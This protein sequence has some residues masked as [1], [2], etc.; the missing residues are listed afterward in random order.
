MTLLRPDGLGKRTRGPH[1]PA[2][3]VE[4]GLLAFGA[5]PRRVTTFLHR[6]SRASNARRNSGAGNGASGWCGRHVDILASS[7]RSC[8][9]R[10]ALGLRRPLDRAGGR[11]RRRR[12]E[13][14]PHLGRDEGLRATRRG[15]L[16]AIR[17]AD[18]KEFLT[19]E[20]GSPVDEPEERLQSC[21]GLGADASSHLRLPHQKG[22]RTTRVRGRRG[23]A[24]SS[25]CQGC[26]LS[27][28][29]G[30]T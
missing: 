15:R 20:D 27:R 4:P 17:R 18:L 12:P 13:A 29:C 5:S 23:D 1:A 24:D 6:G 14:N 26:N 25:R 22:R 3:V 21:D 10:L 2:D 11:G 30:A 7:L 9:P 16:L 28:F 8:A 19:G